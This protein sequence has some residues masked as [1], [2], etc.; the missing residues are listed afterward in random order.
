MRSAYIAVL[1]GLECRSP[2]SPEQDLGRDAIGRSCVD[3][4]EAALAATETLLEDRLMAGYHLLLGAVRGDLSSLV[5][6]VRPMPQ[7]SSIPQ[8]TSHR[9]SRTDRWSDC[10]VP[11]P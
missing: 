2:P 10:V 9:R 4:P 3:G 6:D 5:S 7:Q 11:G 1:V 8:P